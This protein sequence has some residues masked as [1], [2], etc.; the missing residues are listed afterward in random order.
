LP[1]WRGIDSTAKALSWIPFLSFLIPTE[2]GGFRDALKKI[3]F[4]PSAASREQ[5]EHRSPVDF[6]RQISA[7]EVNLVHNDL[8]VVYGVVH[9]EQLLKNMRQTRFDPALAIISDRNIC[10][11][12]VRR[13]LPVGQ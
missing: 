12:V 4:Q 3:S 7:R 13:L 9:W 2:S 1:C 6:H 11:E 8:K 10:R 5:A